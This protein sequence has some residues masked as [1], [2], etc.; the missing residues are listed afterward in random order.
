MRNI[1]SMTNVAKITLLDYTQYSWN[2]VGLI[3]SIRPSTS[4][5]WLH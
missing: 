4:I 1:S 3:N 2:K 5:H